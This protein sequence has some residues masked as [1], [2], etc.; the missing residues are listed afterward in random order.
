MCV[1]MCLLVCARTYVRAES[2]DGVW[3]E[4]GVG[5]AGDFGACAQLSG[6]QL[7]QQVEALLGTTSPTSDLSPITFLSY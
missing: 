3:P 4:V 1:R 7:S 2:G 6:L 5:I